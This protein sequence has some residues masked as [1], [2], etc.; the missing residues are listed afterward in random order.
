MKQNPK[1]AN[2]PP[3]MRELMPKGFLP[4][5]CKR[6]GS[7]NLSN[8]SQVVNLE[9]TNSS[10]WPAVLQLAEETNPAGFQAWQEAQEVSH[11]Q[12]A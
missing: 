5:L 2:R 6:T 4:L 1:P 12:A 8:M 7:G 11:T 10:Y 9:N 3:T